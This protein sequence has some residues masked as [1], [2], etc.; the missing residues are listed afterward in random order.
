MGQTQ[1]GVYENDCSGVDVDT[2]NKHYGIYGKLITHK[3]DQFDARHPAN[4]EASG[5]EDIG[6]TAHTVSVPSYWSPFANPEEKV[7]F[8]ATLYSMISQDVI[9]N[10]FGLTPAE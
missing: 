6:F 8:S 10:G 5:N 7:T 4:E 2:I 3:N 1:F 9:P